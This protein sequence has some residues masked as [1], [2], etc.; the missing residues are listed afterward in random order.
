[1]EHCTKANEAVDSRRYLTV[2]K[3][4]AEREAGGGG[5]EVLFARNAPAHPTFPSHVKESVPRE[6]ED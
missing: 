6:Q 3:K 4:K 1:M 5:K 2:Y